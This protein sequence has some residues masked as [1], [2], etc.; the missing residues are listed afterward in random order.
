MS[1]TRKIKILNEG[2]G[3]VKVEVQGRDQGR[4]VQVSEATITAG[5]FA[6]V[7]LVDGQSFQVL[8]E[9]EA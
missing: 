3:D 8:A 4:F 9:G 6:D 5:T 7:F 1:K 2:P